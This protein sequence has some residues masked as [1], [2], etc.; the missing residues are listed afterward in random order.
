MGRILIRR[1]GETI[2][3]GEYNHRLS[4]FARRRFLLSRN[5]IRYRSLKSRGEE[6]VC[7]GQQ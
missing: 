6:G 4:A 1:G 3:A 5:R 7:A 2:A